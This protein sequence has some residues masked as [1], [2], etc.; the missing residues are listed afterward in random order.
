MLFINAIIT[1]LGL[2]YFSAPPKLGP[3]GYSVEVSVIG[4][5]RAKIERRRHVLVRGETAGTST[6]MR[7]DATS[8]L[9]LEMTAVARAPIHTEMRVV[10]RF[11]SARSASSTRAR[12]YGFGE[13]TPVGHIL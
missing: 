13:K 9:G 12:W 10:D 3:S 4:V 5:R 6:Q 11:L 1:L 2:L 7:R 8:V